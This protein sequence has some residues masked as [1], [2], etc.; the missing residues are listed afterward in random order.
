MVREFSKSHYYLV[1]CSVSWETGYLGYT[2]PIKLKTSPA[3][4][5][6]KAK[7]TAT[8]IPGYPGG[9]PWRVWLLECGFASNYLWEST[10]PY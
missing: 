6:S 7:P 4:A 9:E 3:N 2:L 5:I 8:V 1:Y 10:Y